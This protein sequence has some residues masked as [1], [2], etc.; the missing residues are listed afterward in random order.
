[1]SLSLNSLYMI[2]KNTRRI[3]FYNLPLAYFTKAQRVRH[4]WL[5]TEG[6]S[7]LDNNGS[8]Y[9]VISSNS[10]YFADFR[11]ILSVR[12]RWFFLPGQMPLLARVL[13]AQWRPSDSK[14]E[15]KYWRR[16]D[17]I[18][19]LGQKLDCGDDDDLDQIC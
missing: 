1:L 18:G 16:E 13:R 11:L 10:H 12:P 4:L 19:A 17:I 7:P 9:K 8:L 14:F 2:K 3:H 6:K 15:Q 5:M